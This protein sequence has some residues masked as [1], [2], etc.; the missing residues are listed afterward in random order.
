MP[1]NTKRGPAQIYEN[2][3]LRAFSGLESIKSMVLDSTK[4]PENPTGSARYV[5]VQGTVM[6]KISGSSKVCPVTAGAFGS[7]GSGA[8]V[9][10][11]IVGVLAETIEV[12]VGPGV[13]AGGST[14]EPCSVMFMGADFNVSKLIG[15]GG[16]AP[17]PATS[18][19][20]AAMPLCS[21]R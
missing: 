19:V 3:F 6:G 8:W 17:A 16:S 20:Q 14:D 7:G 12:Y 10:A 18:I 2:E 15:Y 13:T 21:F 9:A 11:D 4:V 5:V 1:F